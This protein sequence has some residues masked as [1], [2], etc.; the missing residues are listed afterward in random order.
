L[1]RVGINKVKII[2]KDII[3]NTF[4]GVVAKNYNL[5]LISLTKES[6]PIVKSK[7]SLI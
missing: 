3:I 7:F 2:I 5:K 4:Y 1:F 6:K